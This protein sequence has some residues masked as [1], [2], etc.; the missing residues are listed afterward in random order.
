MSG[1]GDEIETLG[2]AAEAYCIALLLYAKF[3]SETFG[4]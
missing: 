1:V 3:N 2:S 4:A